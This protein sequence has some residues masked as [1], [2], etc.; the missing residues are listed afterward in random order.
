M[1]L[2]TPEDLIIMK[3]IAHRPQDMIDVQ[4]ILQTYP[5]LDRKRIQKWVK[6]FSDALEN[7]DIWAD[8]R[9]LMKL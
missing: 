3:M 5:R 1:P 6:E 9:N 7:V 8:C 2:P 4:T